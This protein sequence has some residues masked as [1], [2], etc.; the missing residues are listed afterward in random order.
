MELQPRICWMLCSAAGPR[1]LV[2]VV[3][4]ADTSPHQHVLMHML[5]HINITIC[6]EM[7][8][9]LAHLQSELA[10]RKLL[11]AKLS[12][13]GTGC[14]FPIGCNGRIWGMVWAA[15]KHT[16]SIICQAAHMAAHIAATLCCHGSAVVC[17][18][19]AQ[20]RVHAWHGVL[21][22]KMHWKYPHYFR[23]RTGSVRL[24]EV[25]LLVLRL[26]CSSCTYCSCQQ[27]ATC[28]DQKRVTGTASNR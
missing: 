28:D 17:T 4:P 1:Q 27:H 16:M 24:R 15:D 25:R 20:Q 14:L 2:I 21:L 26:P 3:Q 9:A 18:Q 22:T 8:R 6:M 10:S 19:H 7:L 5:M 13:F 11:L 12:V 23:R